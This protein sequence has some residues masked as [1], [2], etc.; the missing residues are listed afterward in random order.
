[1]EPR[2]ME[3]SKENLLLMKN[4]EDKEKR[5]ECDNL[6]F[7]QDLTNWDIKPSLEE[8]KN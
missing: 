7:N 6:V 2:Y 1:M 5:H 8:I 4:I 3:T